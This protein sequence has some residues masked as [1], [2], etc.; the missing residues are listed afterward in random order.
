MPTRADLLLGS[1]RTF[2]VVAVTL[3]MTGA[4]VGGMG[5]TVGITVG[6]GNCVG[7][8]VSASVRVGVGLGL[9]AG[10]TNCAVTSSITA[11]NNKTTAPMANGTHSR[12]RPP[13]A[14]RAGR[15]LGAAPGGAVGGLA[16]AI[17]LG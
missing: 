3:A 16:R 14:A 17:G 9:M 8:R 4:G 12:P 10:N 15:S 7:G 5:V 1:A 2:S 13:N 6:G 11:H